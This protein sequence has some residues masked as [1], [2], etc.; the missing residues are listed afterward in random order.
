MTV[1]EGHGPPLPTSSPAPKTSGLAIASLV[2]GII[3]GI[4]LSIIFGF[5]ALGQI[6]RG[7]RT[8]KGMAIA[9]LVLSGLWVVGAVT[10][11]ALVMATSAERDESGQVVESGSV[12]I[13][14]LRVG[15]CIVTLEEADEVFTLDLV[16]CTESHAGE[17]YGVFDLTG[18]T[19]PSTTELDSEAGQGCV[20][21]LLSYSE[22]AYDDASIEIFY[23]YPSEEGWPG[24]REV[25][26]VATHTSGTMSSSIKEA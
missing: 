8:G 23:F 7:E 14:D 22:E 17:V 1:P 3:G 18:D 6:R 13:M 9:G 2:L 24:D 10:A 26:C 19:Y 21:L 15:D 16:P 12:D 20:D 4:V 11:F 5:V 25:V